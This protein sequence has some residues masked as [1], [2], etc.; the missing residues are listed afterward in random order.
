MRSLAIFIQHCKQVVAQTG[1]LA[2]RVGVV[3]DGKVMLPIMSRRRSKSIVM[4]IRDIRGDD[5]SAVVAAAEGIEMRSLPQISSFFSL[6][7][8]F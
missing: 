3:R 6:S 4:D 5:F 1:P 7:L 2:C 8:I